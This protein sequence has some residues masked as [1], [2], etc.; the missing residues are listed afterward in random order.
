ML[1]VGVCY[2]VISAT[3][4]SFVGAEVVG[5]GTAAPFTIPN[6]DYK[7]LNDSACIR[8]SPTNQTNNRWT[9]FALP[10]GTAPKGGW[11]V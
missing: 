11:P 4:G 6:W 9:H 3:S 5:S 8:T 1:L 2:A 10:K 7:M